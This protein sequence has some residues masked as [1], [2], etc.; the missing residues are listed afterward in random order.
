VWDFDADKA[1]GMIAVNR[2]GQFKDGYIRKQLHFETV[3]NC[4]VTDS[5]GKQRHVTMPPIAHDEYSVSLEPIEGTIKYKAMAGKT[6][7]YEWYPGVPFSPVTAKEYYF[8]A[9]D[10]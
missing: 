3:A 8:E 5:K 6:P 1:T 7:Q 2:Y 4:T 10:Q 9:S